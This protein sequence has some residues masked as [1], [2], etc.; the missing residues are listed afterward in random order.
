LNK[1]LLQREIEVEQ[2]KKAKYIECLSNL[3]V[4]IDHDKKFLGEDVFTLADL[5]ELVLSKFN[6]NAKNFNKSSKFPKHQ[7]PN[8]TNELQRLGE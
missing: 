2:E 5:V 6:Q 3:I 1:E 7:T 4:Y 8:N